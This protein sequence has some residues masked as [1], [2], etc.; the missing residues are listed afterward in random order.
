MNA[1]KRDTI[2]P[3]ITPLIDVVF[4][5]LIFFIVSSVFKKDELAL[6][7]NLPNSNTSALLLKDKDISI[8]LT[9]NKLAMHNK[10]ISFDKFNLAL[11][12]IK[13]KKTNIILHIDENVNYKRIIKVLDAL[14]E[15]NLNKLSLVSK[16]R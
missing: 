13:D 12:T 8:E 4:I 2:S 6:K 5:L 11:K 14:K 16:N 9:S 7:L 10:E 3:D 15:N 1:N